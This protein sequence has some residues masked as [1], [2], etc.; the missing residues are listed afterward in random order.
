MRLVLASQS[1][2][3]K[4]LLRQIGLTFD[5]IPSLLPE[6]FIPALSPEKMVLHWAENKGRDVANKVE[7]SIIIAADTIVVWNNTI[8]G[9][10]RDRAQAYQMLSDLSGTTHQVFTGL[11]VL[12]QTDNYS[13]SYC[14]KTDVTFRSLSQ[15]EIEDYLATGEYQD[16]AG[17]YGIQGR[18]AIFVEKICGCYFN[19][20]GL[21]LQRLNLLLNN[22]IEE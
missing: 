18:A 12:R 22:L 9:K 14:E 11:F 10:P 6:E 2:R 21:P 1:P 5:I 8:L 16:K 3:R 19:I 13:Q 15:G 4:E 7:K 17:A 20:V